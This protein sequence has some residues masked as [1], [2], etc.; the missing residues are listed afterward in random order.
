LQAVWLAC[1]NTPIS[2]AISEVVEPNEEKDLPLYSTVSES[3]AKPEIAPLATQR[4]KKVL[5]LLQVELNPE[6]APWF[7]GTDVLTKDI[8]DLALNRFN[9]AFDRW[10]ELFR[11]AA[12]QR[13]QSRRTMDTHNLPQRERDAARSLH[14]QAIDQLNLLQRGSDSSASDF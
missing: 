9:D 5:A 14:A 4:I 3:L 13:D 12:R 10:R 6:D 11:S 1:T 2:A 7:R 8:T